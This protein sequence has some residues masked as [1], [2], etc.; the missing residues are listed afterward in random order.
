[1]SSL[2]HRYYF[3]NQGDYR[4]YIRLNSSHFSYPKGRILGYNYIKFAVGKST[5][6]PIA[7]LNSGPGYDKYSIRPYILQDKAMIVYPYNVVCYPN[8]YT[9]RSYRNGLE[10]SLYY[11]KYI[12]ENCASP[13]E[14]V[15]IFPE[16]KKD[17]KTLS[18][19][20]FYVG[21][22]CVFNH[23]GKLLV[24]TY[25]RMTKLGW[26]EYRPEKCVL[27]VSQEVLTKQDDSL[28]KIIVKEIIPVVLGSEYHFNMNMI[29]SDL[30]CQSPGT[31]KVLLPTIMEVNPD[32]N[33]NKETIPP[34]PGFDYNAVCREA[35]N[36]VDNIIC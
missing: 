29:D 35:S 28:N 6:V 24:G 23:E 13:G 18:G 15:Q 11:M 2:Q 33:P 32:I 34:V 5:D 9:D 17:G 31:C 10:H 16:F 36:Y 7:V 22:G 14:L 1:M 21:N 26:R 3:L 20:P 27:K 25:I 4:E 30:W 19:S 8:R 12:R